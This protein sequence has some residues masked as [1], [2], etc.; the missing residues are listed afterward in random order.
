[1]NISKAIVLAGGRGT[2]LPDSARDIPKSLVEIKGKTILEHQ[3][4]RLKRAG[5]ESVRLALGFRAD[6]IIDFVRSRGYRCEWVIEPEP[7]GT[8]GAIKFASADLD[9]PFLVLNGDTLADFDFRAIAGFHR[10]QTSLVVSYWQDDC[11][12]F[13]LL[14]IENDFIRGFFEKPKEAIGG[15][16]NA[17]CYILNSG[18]LTLVPENSFMLENEVFPRL[19]KEGRLRTYIHRGFWED[20]GVEER[21]AKVRAMDNIFR[22]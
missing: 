14:E 7:L 20:L 10:P 1:M 22:Q 19:A 15:H 8:G 12:D 13:G 5:F 21:L 2:R 11:R 18:D 9:G 4:Q 16:I 6:Q 17:G 3:I